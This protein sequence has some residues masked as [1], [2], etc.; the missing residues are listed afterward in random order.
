MP[1]IGHDDWLLKNKLKYRIN[2]YLSACQIYTLGKKAVLLMLTDQ[3]LYWA[4]HSASP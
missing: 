1:I 4:F 2:Y 3:F